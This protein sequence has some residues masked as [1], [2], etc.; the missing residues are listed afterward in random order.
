VATRF[1]ASGEHYS[2]TNGAVTGTFSAT[3]WVY[4]SVDR[5]AFSSFLAF[6]SVATS[7]GTYLEL[8]IDQDRQLY[9]FSN[10]GDVD[11]AHLVDVGVWYRI[12]IV[13]VGATGTLYYGTGNSLTAVQSTISNGTRSFFFIGTNGYGE[14]LDG[15]IAGVKVW[16][17]ELTQSEIEAEFVSLDPVR[18]ANLLRAHKLQVPETTDY[19]G[20][21][22]TLTGGTGASAEADPPVGILIPEETQNSRAVR[23]MRRSVAK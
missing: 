7:P 3:C 12:G 19:S 23:T 20:S 8:G 9:L 13:V 22:N 11:S 15:R 10:S 21:S 4:V 1:D 2:A 14:W 18:T 5:V 16:S 6:E 17:A